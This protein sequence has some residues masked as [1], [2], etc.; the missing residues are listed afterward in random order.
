MLRRF[1]PLLATSDPQNPH[2]GVFTFSEE[3][4]RLLKQLRVACKLA[5]PDVAG[6]RKKFITATNKSDYWIPSLT[7]KNT[8]LSQ[9]LASV[10]LD[11]ETPVVHTTVPYGAIAASACSMAL[12]YCTGQV[13]LDNDIQRN[14]CR[15]AQ[16]DRDQR[17]RVLPHI[18]VKIRKLL[19]QCPGNVI[20]QTC[21]TSFCSSDH[22]GLLTR[23]VQTKAAAQDDLRN[24]FLRMEEYSLGRIC[25]EGDD[26]RFQKKHFS[27]L[28]D[29][30]QHLIVNKLRLSLWIFGGTK[31][32]PHARVPNSEEIAETRCVHY[33]RT[34]HE[35]KQKSSCT[36]FEKVLDTKTSRARD[37]K[38]LEVKCTSLPFLTTTIESCQVL[39]KS[40]LDRISFRDRC[41]QWIQQA[42]VKTHVEQTRYSVDKWVRVLQC[43]ESARCLVKYNL[44]YYIRAVELPQ[45]SFVVLRR[46]HHG[47][48]DAEVASERIWT[49]QQQVAV[50]SYV[51]S[52]SKPTVQDIRARKS[53]KW[54][55]LILCM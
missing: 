39:D 12:R 13:I 20:S 7:I 5:Q 43:R 24:I 14:A 4:E 49:P 10:H 19:A 55:L 26:L 40:L 50:R 37:T 51:N 36:D 33:M 42:N 44:T 22:A 2:R 52:H 30:A 21:V 38:T 28:G 15:F 29:F 11:D 8:I 34:E 18:D 41:T 46:G 1:S 6:S 23:N 35:D 54:L 9:L 25:G 16:Q 45:N 27:V 31:E 53:K 32:I 17:D 47:H 48:D 3:H